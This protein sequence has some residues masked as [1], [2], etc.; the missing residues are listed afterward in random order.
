MKSHNFDPA[1]DRRSEPAS[2]VSIYADKGSS[3]DERERIV[4]TLLNVVVRECARY[5][6]QVSSTATHERHASRSRRSERW[7][8]MRTSREMVR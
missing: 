1:S 5:A 6:T 4:L 7:R 8:C 3:V 2:I